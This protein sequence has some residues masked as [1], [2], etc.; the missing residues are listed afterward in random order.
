MVTI[1]YAAIDSRVPN[2][3]AT[4]YIVSFG[5]LC[6]IRHPQLSAEFD[7][8]GTTEEEE[9][10]EDENGHPPAA[11]TSGGANAVRPLDPSLL[12][13]LS[14]VANAN[15]AEEEEALGKVWMYSFI[16]C[17]YRQIRC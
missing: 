15:L 12:E 17:A 1:Q 11:A 3:L 14:V 8:Q 2:S 7:S 5:S 6:F 10:G 13:A 4:K 9:E 16:V